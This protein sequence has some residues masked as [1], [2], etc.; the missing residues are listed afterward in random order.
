MPVFNLDE[1]KIKVI[2]VKHEQLFGMKFFSIFKM[3]RNQRYHYEP[4]YY[5]EVKEDIEQRTSR[6]KMELHREGQQDLDDKE[7]YAAR[8]AHSYS[9][10]RQQSS[11]STNLTQFVIMILLSGTAV[12]YL[13]FGNIA[14]Y[15]ILFI[16]PVYLYLRIKGKL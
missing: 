10:R 11:K 12:A 16:T 7:V 15:P 8:I 4:R 1:N 5:D 6:I 2:F 14:L 9:K 13:Y 3:P